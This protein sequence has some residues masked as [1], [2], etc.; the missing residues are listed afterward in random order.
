M[1]SQL[2][3]V[4]A[5]LVVMFGTVAETFDGPTPTDPP[6][7]FILVGSSG[8]DDEDVATTDREWAP[9]GNRWIEETGEVVCS[10]WVQSGD[11]DLV[12]RRARQ[13]ELFDACE[14]AVLADPTLGGLC[15]WKEPAF[16]PRTRLR[17]NQAN[18]GSLAR[19][20]FS[21]RYQALLT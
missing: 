18:S 21:V 10:I 1:P 13:D 12:G 6:A 4:I 17:Q 11:T 14:A 19:L 3:A 15:N 2:N 16:I 7:E 9:E 5:Y 20:I 8:D